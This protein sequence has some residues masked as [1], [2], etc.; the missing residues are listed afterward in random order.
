MTER[1]KFTHISQPAHHHH[2]RKARQ[3]LDTSI[4]PSTK[5]SP[6]S[7]HNSMPP[8]AQSQKK[9]KRE[10]LDPKRVNQGLSEND[11]DSS[12]GEQGAKVSLKDSRI[13]L[14]HDSPSRN[15][16][17]HSS[18]TLNSSPVSIRTPELKL[19]KVTTP[20]S[21]KIVHSLSSLRDGNERIHN[22]E[23]HNHSTAAEPSPSQTL[24]TQERPTSSQ[25]QSLKQSPYPP[26]PPSFPN[27]N[28]PAY[29]Q[30]QVERIHYQQERVS[31]PNHQN[32]QSQH[33]YHHYHHPNHPLPPPH[34]QST[35]ASQSPAMPQLSGGGGAIGNHGS[36]RQK[37]G[38]LSPIPGGNSKVGSMVMQS[39]V[40]PPLIRDPL[41]VQQQGPSPQQQQNPSSQQHIT[42]Q[43]HIQ[44][45][46]QHT[47][48]H[49]PSPQQHNPS[50]QPHNSSQRIIPSPQQHNLSPQQHM[51]S[52]QENN[53]QA[54]LQ[55]H[56]Q[57]LHLRSLHLQRT[58]LGG[59]S[60]GTQ[61]LNNPHALLYQERAEGLQYQQ[62]LMAHQKQIEEERLKQQQQQKQIEE[63]R[64]KQ[65]QIEEERL[66]QQ[67][68]QKQF[69]EERLKQIEEE[70]LKQ[71]QKLMQLEHQK[72]L[73]QQLQLKRSEGL[74]QYQGR[75]SGGVAGSAGGNS[76]QMQQNILHQQMLQRQQQQQQQQILLHQAQMQQQQQQQQQYLL[77][78]GA[79]HSPSRLVQPSTPGLPYNIQPTSSNYY[80]PMNQMPPGKSSPQMAHLMHMRS[81]QLLASQEQNRT[82]EQIPH[83]MMGM[84][85]HHHYPPPGA[86]LPNGANLA[87]TPREPNPIGSPLRHFNPHH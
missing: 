5:I 41:I 64:L 7:Q 44:S 49:N 65:K 74:P 78:Q 76:G 2:Q 23:A 24:L 8:E 72:L 80:T 1:Q 22:K 11:G 4:S 30:S 40:S 19:K 29:H 61:F 26:P 57:A 39:G 75:H 73:E 85:H 60:T 84:T 21:A 17:N 87:G 68:Q 47:Q 69:E 33:Q 52:P 79:A 18:P 43:Q 16:S 28:Q 15:S 54:Q 63:E 32:S 62:K 77:Q 48:S 31:T 34:T 67:Q 10:D 50:P 66:K 51:P 59:S 86:A 14:L 82:I 53:P 25:L 3:K 42:H 56:N 46:R 55:S 70:R 58:P 81:Q 27:S 83:Q 38:N 71:Q 45:S 13:N 37:S 36:G 6:V 35:S 9:M 20:T 12:T